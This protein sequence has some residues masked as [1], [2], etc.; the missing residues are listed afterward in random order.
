[1]NRLLALVHRCPYQIALSWFCFCSILLS[2]GCKRPDPPPRP[3]PKPILA[4][5]QPAAPIPAKRNSPCRWYDEPK[6]EESAKFFP[7]EKGYRFTSDWFTPH[8]PRWEK[9]LAPFKGK[10]ELRY[11]EIGAFEGRSVVWM[12]NNILTHPT[13]RMTAIDVFPGN[14][15]ARY[16]YNLGRSGGADKVTTIQG[17]SSPEL[18]KFPFRS[19]DII[20]I[21][22][23]HMADD[24]LTDAALSWD[25]LRN[26][27]VLIFD[28]YNWRPGGPDLPPE[29]QPQIAIDAFLTANRNALEVLDR[30]YQVIV[31]KKENP[32]RDKDRCSPL[33]RFAFLWKDKVLVS[34]DAK[35]TTV[36]LSAEENAL[37]RRILIGRPFGEVDYV[38][39]PEMGNPQLAANLAQRLGFTL[40]FA[41]AP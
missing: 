22:G 9:A 34:L 33:G 39:R 27:G 4:P 1:M 10:P 31:R 8:L 6:P 40:A 24:V 15:K 11:L 18:R 20:Y 26:G 23:S 16:L 36:P 19:F 13:A 12:L 32:C 38:W 21:D 7:P 30:C 25:L 17:Y 41:K 29:L 3:H 37:L 2:I 14:L 35:Q 28:D 5:L